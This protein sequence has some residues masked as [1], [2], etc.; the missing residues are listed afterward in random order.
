MATARMLNF[1][2]E[3][4]AGSAHMDITDEMVPYETVA[5]LT[6]VEDYD[7]TAEG[8]SY[9]WIFT[10]SAET[11]AGRTAP[12]REWLA[13]TDG[14][15]WKTIQVLEAHEYEM[16]EGQQ[17][18]DPES[19]LGE[20]VGVIIDYPRDRQGEPQG[21]FKEIVKYFPLVGEPQPEGEAP[22]FVTQEAEP[23]LL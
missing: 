23:G 15:K 8:K 1:S 5:T 19:L 11:P 17:L 14:A 21:D 9:G 3:D 13:Q 6:K 22:S 12:Y 7:K 10:Y 18:F 2:K 16:E 20:V 4:L